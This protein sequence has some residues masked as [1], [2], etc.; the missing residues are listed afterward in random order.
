[1]DDE[2]VKV[3]NNNKDGQIYDPGTMRMTKL[4]KN[5]ENRDTKYKAGKHIHSIQRKQTRKCQ[6]LAE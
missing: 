4:T 1:M 3:E 6:K 2:D 5:N